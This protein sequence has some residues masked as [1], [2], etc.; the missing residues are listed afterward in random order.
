MSDPKL[1]IS[2]DVPVKRDE[3]SS[4]AIPRNTIGV[5][6]NGN[7]LQIPLQGGIF[8]VLLALAVQAWV[9]F[10]NMKQDVDNANSTLDALVTSMQG[11]E[12]KLGDAITASSANSTQINA[13]E[14]DIEDLELENKE[15]EEKVR[16]LE[17]CHSKP[18]KCE[19]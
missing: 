2:V 7:K 17:V 12:T 4:A 15:L 8:S 10:G 11:I 6:M 5:R 14:S 19:L 18:K 1:D 3:K 9:W 13:L 16:V